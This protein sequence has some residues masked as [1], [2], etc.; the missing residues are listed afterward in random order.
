MLGTIESCSL[1]GVDAFRVAVEV[2][3]D[4]GLPRYEV[5]GLPNAS[6]REGAVRIRAALKAAGHDLP[7]KRVTVNLAPADRRKEGAAFDLPIA[8][9]V[10]IGD[11][12]GTPAPVDGLLV[13]GELGLDG[14]L[15]PVRGVLAAALLARQRGMRGVLVPAASAAEAQAVAGIDVYAAAH[16]GEI[17]RA[18]LGEA[19]LPRPEPAPPATPAPPEGDAGD[20]ADVRGQ[21]LARAAVEVAV[22]GGHNLLFVGP[23]GVGKTMLARRIPTVLPPLSDGE[24]VDTTKV[25]S[26]LGLAR[27]GLIRARPFRAP[28]HTVSTAALLGGGS[29]PRPGELSLAHNGVL[30]LDELPEFSR[31][32]IEALRQPLEDRQVTIARVRGTVTLPASVMLVASAN[33]CPCGWHGSPDRACTCTFGAIERYRDRLS[34]PL[35]DRIDLQVHVPNVALSDMRS[36]EP[37]ESSA[38]IRARVVAARAR[39][40]RRLA[41]FGVATNADMGP[42]AMRATCPL[43]ARAEAALAKLHRT[44]LGLTGRGIDRVI[45]V[46]RTI[47]DLAGDD[48]IDAPAVLEAAS[49]RALDLDPV[50][51]ARRVAGA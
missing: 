10:L 46:A 23:P 11:R 19:P 45:K 39:Q 29:P 47:A 8:I 7:N 48:V 6:V 1:L 37:G 21:A 22:A 12:Q 15:R 44:R 35:L 38:A 16:I 5:V 18:L 40:A 3:V 20:M 50:A 17:R 9:G 34:G 32:A 33:P 2:S 41:A 4:G 42:R 36:A 49:Y 51:D 30:F 31:V 13:V 26:A 27:D 14:S 43:T 28:H 24:A 25:Y